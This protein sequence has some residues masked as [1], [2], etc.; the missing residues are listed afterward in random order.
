MYG[1]FNLLEC[2]IVQINLHN[3]ILNGE[4]QKKNDQELK[5]MTTLGR[6]T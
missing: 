2:A 3:C 1:F 4:K 5:N 6:W